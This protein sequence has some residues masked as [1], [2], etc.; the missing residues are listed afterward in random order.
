MRTIFISLLFIH[1]ISGIS[2]QS[3][4]SNSKFL[5]EGQNSP[6]ANLNDISWL[7]GYWQGEAF[8]GTTEEIWS[9]PSAGSMMGSFK[10][11]VDH[12]VS[13][14]EFMTITE[15]KNS[16]LMKIKHF[17]WELL[18]WEEK[19]ESVEFKLVEV[20]PNQVFFEGLSIQRV[21]ENEIII[22]VVIENEGKKSEVAFPY[23]RK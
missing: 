2:A 10:L 23:Q 18:G 7:A 8:G 17:D 14:Y 22:Y 21:N 9:V 12:Q 15:E 19:D 16:L 5:E 11:I 6:N 20:L 1:L 13:F 4:F 3:A